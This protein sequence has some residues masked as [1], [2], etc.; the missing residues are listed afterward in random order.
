LDFLGANPEVSGWHPPDFNRKQ[1]KH[2]IQMTNAVREALR[3]HFRDELE[4][5]AGLFGGPANEW[6]MRYNL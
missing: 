1:G 4:R 2:K 6:P 3:L 5:C